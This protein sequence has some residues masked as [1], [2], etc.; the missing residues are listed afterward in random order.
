MSYKIAAGS[1]NGINIDLKFAEVQEF[2]IYE[3]ENTNFKLM[4][5]RKVPSNGIEK[6][7]KLNNKKPADCPGNGH[8]CDGPTEAI[9]KVEL[10][11]DCRAVLCTKIGFQAQKQFERKAISVFDVNCT[12]Q[13]AISKIA[14]Y[15]E[16]VDKHESLRGSAKNH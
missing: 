8:G 15:Y 1:S 5:K 13:E 6:E 12:I 16:K 4:E 2:F 11:S 7:K 3:V 9:A 10:I 14:K